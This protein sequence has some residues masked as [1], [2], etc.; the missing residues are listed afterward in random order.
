[1]VLLVEFVD[2][3]LIEGCIDGDFVCVGDV[4]LLL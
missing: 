3:F 2:D 4:D 1:M